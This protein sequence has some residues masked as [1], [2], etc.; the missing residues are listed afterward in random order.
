MCVREREKNCGGGGEGR[1]SIKRMIFLSMQPSCLR[2]PCSLFVTF[3]L[4]L[5]ASPGRYLHF[6]SFRVACTRFPVLIMSNVQ[7][8]FS[9]HRWAAK[10]V[11]AVRYVFPPTL[12]SPT[13]V[14]PTYLDLPCTL[15]IQSV[16]PYEQDS[17]YPWQTRG[18]ITRFW[19][20]VTCLVMLSRQLYS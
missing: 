16:L 3:K 14:P 18:H 7:D 6:G 19:A 17:A 4:F 1:S 11:Y 5:L 12:L 15:L 10:L 20:F 2:C 13:T 9:N 8:L